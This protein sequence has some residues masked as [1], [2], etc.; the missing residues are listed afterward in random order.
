[1]VDIVDRT[2]KV[3]TVG[4]AD[5]AADRNKFAG[6]ARYVSL[7]DAAQSIPIGSDVAVFHI[8]RTLTAGRRYDID[9][10]VADVFSGAGSY[11]EMRLYVDGALRQNKSIRT[12]GVAASGGRLRWFFAVTSTRAVEVIVQAQ[13]NGPAAG[14]VSAGSWLSI[15]D[16]GPTS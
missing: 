4:E 2:P 7:N 14:T 5:T 16:V 1:M 13:I 12:D 10:D 6:G 11:I 9:V 8:I 3:W 15:T